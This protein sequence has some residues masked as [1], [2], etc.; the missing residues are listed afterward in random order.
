METLTLD[1]SHLC[2]SHSVGA[3]RVAKQPKEGGVGRKGHGLG[4]TI[5]ES[6]SRVKNFSFGED[7]SNCYFSSMPSD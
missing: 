3:V 2:G 4:K 7:A 5:P 1:D 6:T